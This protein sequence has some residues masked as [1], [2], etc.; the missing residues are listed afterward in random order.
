MSRRLTVVQ[1]GV[2]IADAF[3]PLFAQ[4]LQKRGYIP[5]ATRITPEQVKDI[6]VLD[7]S[8]TSEQPGSL[9]SLRGIEY[10]ESLDTLYCS[11]NQ[12]TM[13]DVSQNTALT[14]LSC[15]GNQLTTLDVS[16]NTALKSLYCYYNLLTTLDVSQN[17]AL[18]NLGCYGNQLTTLDVSKNKALMVLSCEYNQLTTLDVSQNTALTRFYC[19]GNQLTMLDV[20]QNT[21]LK[22]LICYNNPGDGVS[23]FPVTAWFDNS[24]VPSSYF[25]TGGW[26]YEGKI[27]SVDYRKAD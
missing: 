22:S 1:E 23:K 6:E 16:Q 3:D 21:A 12:L 9:T 13:L 11:Y 5:D 10:F 15:Y 25:T 20:S 7:V 2:N 4:E 19:S 27:I 17:T 8:G 18:T 14:N 26:A 24:A